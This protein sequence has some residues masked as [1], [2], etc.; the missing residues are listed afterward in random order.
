MI[1]ALSERPEGLI[2]EDQ[3][4]QDGEPDRRLGQPLP[5]TVH[6]DRRRRHQDGDQQQAIRDPA[7]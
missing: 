3:P 5:A 1:K 2:D 6:A 4:N 7:S